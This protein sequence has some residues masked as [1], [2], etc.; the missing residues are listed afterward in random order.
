M[1]EGA[2]QSARDNYVNQFA[3]GTVHLLSST[4]AVADGDTTITSDASATT[5]TS[6]WTITHD[7]STGET[8]LE[9]A[10]EISLGSPSGFVVD[11]IVIQNANDSTKFVV[12]SN[13][14]GDT[15]LAGDGSTS[16]AAGALS[17]TFGT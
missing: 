5:A 7:N 14:T 13:P 10:N 17:Y 2:N 1:P 15:D 12:V 11:Q 9:N 6:D 4:N 8:T 3:G 16:F